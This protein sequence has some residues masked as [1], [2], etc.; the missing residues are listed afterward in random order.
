MSMNTIPCWMVK[1]SMIRQRERE[2][3]SLLHHSGGSADAKFY[4]Y[5]CI[6]HTLSLSHVGRWVPT[7][8]LPHPRAAFRT[9]IGPPLYHMVRS[10]RS[11]SGLSGST[12]L[13]CVKDSQRLGR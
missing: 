2:L 8:S 10:L 1:M 11:A 4:K 6:R 9:E 3:N 13:H 12:H 7:N 5:I